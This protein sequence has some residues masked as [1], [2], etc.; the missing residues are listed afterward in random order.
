MFLDNFIFKPVKSKLQ[1][2]TKT[3]VCLT[4]ILSAITSQKPQE[5]IHTFE[6]NELENNAN[7]SMFNKEYDNTY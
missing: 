4:F 2:T 1:Q 7:A 3:K 5:D 6:T